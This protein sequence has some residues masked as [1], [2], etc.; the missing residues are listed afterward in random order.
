MEGEDNLTSPPAMSPGPPRMKRM[1]P[2]RSERRDFAHDKIP[3]RDEEEVEG[4]QGG[5]RH[6]GESWRRGR[7]LV[8]KIA[9]H[10]VG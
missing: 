4:R 1:E 7:R 10:E 3:R 5:S 6:R 8:C 9:L 2:A